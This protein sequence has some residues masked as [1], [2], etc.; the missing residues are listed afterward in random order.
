VLYR[1]L[2]L[3]TTPVGD[4]WEAL[5]TSSCQ[6]RHA[7]PTPQSL[8]WNS[9]RALAPSRHPSGRG[10]YL[11]SNHLLLPPPF[12]PVLPF[13]FFAAWHQSTGAIPGT[14]LQPGKEGG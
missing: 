9:V 12:Y 13:F 7:A 2:D 1:V 5:C 4:G 14:T 6:H 3:A 10:F 8:G 11:F